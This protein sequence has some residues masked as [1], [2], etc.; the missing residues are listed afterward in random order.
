MA[1]EERYPRPGFGLWSVRRMECDFRVELL[2]CFRLVFYGMNSPGSL[3][4]I[5]AFLGDRGE[6]GAFAAWL[7]HGMHRAVML[8][9]SA[10]A[11]WEARLGI[12]GEQGRRQQ[13]AE[14]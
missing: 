12:R 14:H 5:R 11:G 8:A 2:S 3:R 4:Q 7:L 13:P 9:A 1:A 10:A 6:C